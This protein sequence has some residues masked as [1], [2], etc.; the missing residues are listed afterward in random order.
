MGLTL[1]IADFIARRDALAVP[2]EAAQIIRRGFQDC[3]G[4]LI[5]G[6]EQP[7]AKIVRGL[8]A[9]G[10][11]YGALDRALCLGAAAHALDYDDTSLNAH[12][13][14]VLV[15]TIL[16][17]GAIVGADGPAM[18]AAYAV[19]FEVW[20]ELTA[21]EP[22]PLHVKGWHPTA[23]L[24][25]IA[26]AAAAA[27]LR[28]LSTEV[29]ARALGIAASLACGV[30]ANFGSHTKPFQVGWAS[31]SGI[32]AVSLA[33]SG[34]SASID[35]IEHSAG[36]LAALS[37]RGL[38]DRSSP[39]LLGQRWKIVEAGLN[40]KLSPVCYASH[41]AID[42]VQGLCE[43]N[44]FPCSNVSAVKI[45][46]GEAQAAMLR[47]KMPCS[48]AEARFSVE[49]AVAATM[50]AGRCSLTELH[51]DFIQR[52]ELRGLMA[53]MKVSP[54]SER[55]AWEVSFSPFDRVSVYLADG[56]TLVSRAVEFSIG[57][58]RNPA[59]DEEY[60]RKFFQCVTPSLGNS[61]ASTLFERLQRLDTGVRA[62][63]LLGALDGIKSMAA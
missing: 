6:W 21:R 29:A 47:N 45:E 2:F 1:E 22:D 38:A 20:A 12:P 62:V 61:E 17:E 11:G 7:V 37:P 53:R 42:A 59:P 41:R 60:Q 14:A 50:I 33:E 43:D 8:A 32:L 3:V 34:M 51:E 46:I 16:A 4:V 25:V 13:S 49:F 58:S 30:V 44:K 52:A 55:S 5:A 23:T 18:I 40:I 24:G 10:P 31:R 9:G 48:V 56:R 54:I 57:H 15:P 26:A 63:D 19:G 36:L 39:A 28:G 35:A 27:V